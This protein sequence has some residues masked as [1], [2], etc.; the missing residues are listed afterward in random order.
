MAT[1]ANDTPNV[2]ATSDVAVNELLCFM[3]QKC[4]VLEV[5]A[6]IKICRD[7]YCATQICIARTS[8]G[9]VAGWLAGWVAGC[10]VISLT[11]FQF[12]L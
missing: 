11:I 6:I 9:V 2:D 3:Q 10:S 1:S 5:D 4:N 12:Q 8:Y 7:F